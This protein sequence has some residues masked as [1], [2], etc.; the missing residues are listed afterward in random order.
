MDHGTHLFSHEILM[1]N[2]D[3]PCEQSNI[4][5]ICLLS[6]SF[7]HTAG[8]WAR[9]TELWCLIFDPL[10]SVKPKKYEDSITGYLFSDHM[11]NLIKFDKKFDL[12]I[13]FRQYI[14]TQ[15]FKLFS[16]LPIN[17]SSKRREKNVNCRITRGKF[18]VYKCPFNKQSQDSS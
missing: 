17:H 7:E 13:K 18:V 16:D 3:E 4:V 8:W 2:Y 1:T 5:A 14:L 9:A 12:L 11:F 6:L 10:S 15:T